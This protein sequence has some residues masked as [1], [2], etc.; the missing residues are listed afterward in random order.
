MVSKSLKARTGKAL[1]W[2]M[3]LQQFCHFS[4]AIERKHIRPRVSRENEI[5]DNDSEADDEMANPRDKGAAHS[6]DVSIRNYARE[7]GF[8]KT[9]TAD[10]TEL[11]IW[12]S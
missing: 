2:E 12:F 6:T 9:L 10:S 1:G 4:L 11:C 3:T 7:S 8:T 5:E